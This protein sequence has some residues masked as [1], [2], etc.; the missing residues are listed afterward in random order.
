VFTRA[1]DWGDSRAMAIGGAGCPP[2]RE[3]PSAPRVRL[4]PGATMAARHTRTRHELISTSCSPEHA[5][6]SSQGRSH[7]PRDLAL[8]PSSVLRLP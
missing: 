8:R 3:G 7:A 1:V 2:S 6:G 5:P 4:H